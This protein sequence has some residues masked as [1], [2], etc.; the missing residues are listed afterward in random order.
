MVNA[1]NF[2]S[3]DWNALT[4]ISLFIYHEIERRGVPTREDLEN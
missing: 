3:L 4:S 2:D 1:K